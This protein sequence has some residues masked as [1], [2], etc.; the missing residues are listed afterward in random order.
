MCFRKK[1]KV[2]ENSRKSKRKKKEKDVW[3]FNGQ[4]NS[5][6]QVHR[7]SSPMS[8]SSS[9]G[10]LQRSVNI[11]ALNSHYIESVFAR[12][13]MGKKKT[14]NKKRFVFVPFVVS[15]ACIRAAGAIK[16]PFRPDLE[17]LLLSAQKQSP[18]KPLPVPTHTP[19]DAYNVHPG[20]VLYTLLWDFFFFIY[21]TLVLM[22]NR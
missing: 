4:W 8:F 6:T 9:R 5:D 11:D 12:T 19:R 14:Y 21:V 18:F 3:K 10:R 15:A 16:I 17:S 2:K 20:Y 22:R 1:K 13:R 7:L